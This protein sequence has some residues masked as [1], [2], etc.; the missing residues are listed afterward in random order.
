MI[1]E[2]LSMETEQG[3]G[4]GGPI[5]FHRC[6]PS[7][8]PSLNFL[9]SSLSS[10]LTVIP[11]PQHSLSFPLS[12]PIQFSFPSSFPSFNVLPV[13][14]LPYQ[15]PYLWGRNMGKDT[16]GW[17]MEQEYKH[18]DFSPLYSQMTFHWWY[19]RVRGV[20]RIW[21]RKITLHMLIAAWYTVLYIRYNTV[22]EVKQIIIL[23][24]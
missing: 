1:L 21:N 20:L 9:P 13:V 3:W 22:V 16:R 11:L 15:Y 17:P 4:E 24:M 10:C 23:F 5:I 8:P 14:L 19:H 6:L 7:L 2:Q 18:W 12:Y